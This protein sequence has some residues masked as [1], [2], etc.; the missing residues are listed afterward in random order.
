MK[1]RRRLAGTE[2]RAGRARALGV[3]GTR[4][5]GT[6]DGRKERVNAATHGKPSKACAQK[7][8]K[9]CIRLTSTRY[10]TQ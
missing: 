7:E 2:S 6:W 10:T 9:R 5:C 4:L 1:R 8:R 3:D